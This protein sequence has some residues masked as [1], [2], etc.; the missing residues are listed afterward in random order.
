MASPVRA[1]SASNGNERRISKKLRTRIAEEAKL[2]GAAILVGVKPSF[3]GIGCR[4]LGKLELTIECVRLRALR[5]GSQTHADRARTSC[6][7]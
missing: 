2:N 6:R 7:R 3:D 1:R 4:P 5:I